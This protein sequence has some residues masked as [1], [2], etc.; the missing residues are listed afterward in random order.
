MLKH[1][2][3]RTAQSSDKT[4]YVDIMYD[5]NLLPRWTGD[6]LKEALYYTIWHDNLVLS[7]IKSINYQCGKRIEADPVIS[8]QHST[9][10]KGDQ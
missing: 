4:K 8:D 6:S 10:A 9:I 3:T 2:Q 7:L 1:R 5:R